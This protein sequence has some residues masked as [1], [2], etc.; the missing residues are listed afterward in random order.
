MLLCAGC[1][2]IKE[3]IYLNSDGSGEYWIYTDLIG[4]S[5]NMMVTMMT[6]LNPE[7]DEDSL[8]Q[9][10]ED[11]LWQE[12]PA[13]VDS[14]LDISDK[15]P[16]SIRNDPEKRKYLER[17][18]MFMEGSKAKGYL[19]S[20]M[21]FSFNGMDDLEAFMELLDQSSKS[22]TGGPPMPATQIEYGFEKNSFSRTAILDT[23]DEALDDSTMMV[24]EGMLKESSWQ[25]IVHL[26]KKAK[27]ASKEQLL[28]KEGKIVIYEYDLLKIVSG[29][30]SMDM[31]IEFWWIPGQ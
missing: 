14:I 15:V 5:R 13:E 3:E 24:L 10:I 11:Q 12:Y 1:F 28:S 30:Q 6:S 27:K 17:M 26:P 4:G 22:S 7:A 8:L 25:L 9:V 18:E 20:G 21:R 2:S 16:D 23:M 31:K 29:E 19:N